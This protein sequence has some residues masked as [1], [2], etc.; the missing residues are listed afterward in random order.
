MVIH[1][2]VYR[3]HVVKG[4]RDNPP[5]ASVVVERWYMAPGVKRIEVQ[6][7]GIT[8]TLFIPPGTL[9]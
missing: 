3:G 4:F 5:M 2:S 6:E 8:G 7:R 9:N 1:I